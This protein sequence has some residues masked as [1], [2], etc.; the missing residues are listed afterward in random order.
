[1]KDIAESALETVRTGYGDVAHALAKTLAA[2]GWLE[3][4]IAA[5]TYLQSTD[6]HV[7]VNPYIDVET[8]LIRRTLASDESLL[9]DYTDATGET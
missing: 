8:Q 7:P 6:R 2:H 4:W 9:G 3:G 5:L 1:M